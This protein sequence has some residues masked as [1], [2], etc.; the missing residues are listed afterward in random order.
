M[1]DNSLIMEFFSQRLKNLRETK[2]IS[3]RELAGRTGISYATI[4]RYES[5]LREPDLIIAYKI[6]TFFNVTVEYLCGEDIEAN[7]EKLL[8]YFKNLSEDKKLDAMKYITY[9]S[10]K[11]R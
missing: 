10:E 8:Y 5:K 11:E 1:K 4:S 9:L 6:A 3:Q 2:G 7:E